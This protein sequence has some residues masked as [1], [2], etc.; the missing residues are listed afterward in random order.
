MVKN[1][2]LTI[3]EG[4]LIL[5]RNTQIIFRNTEKIALSREI[6]SPSLRIKTCNKP[7]KNIP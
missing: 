2:S 3:E 4:H 5:N 7:S 6:D 1:L